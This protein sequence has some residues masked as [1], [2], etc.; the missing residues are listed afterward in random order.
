MFLSIKFI[1][2][3]MEKKTSNMLMFQI[4][5]K[6]KCSVVEGQKAVGC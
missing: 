3:L 1:H 5:D 6:R 4:L 2:K